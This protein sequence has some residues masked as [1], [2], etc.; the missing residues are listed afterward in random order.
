VT[1]GWKEN[2]DRAGEARSTCVKGFGWKRGEAGCCC[3]GGRSMAG[4]CCGGKNMG[5]KDM[6]GCCDGGRGVAEDCD[7]N[8]LAG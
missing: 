4:C 7:R 6:E 8:M 5:G 1:E 2:G 3:S